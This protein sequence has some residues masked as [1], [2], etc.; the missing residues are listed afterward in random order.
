M[1]V[2]VG[3][4]ALLLYFLILYFCIFRDESNA[5][6]R[7]SFLLAGLAFSI[8]FVV[9]RGDVGTDTANYLAMAQKIDVDSG[10]E[11]VDLDVE[12]GF[13]WLLKGLVF[14]FS[15]PRIA[16]NSISFFIAIYSLHLFSRSDEEFLVFALLLF[17]VFFFDMTMNGLRYGLAFLLAKHAS[18]EYR[19]GNKSKSIIYLAGSVGFQLSGVLV[20]F[21]LWMDK[22]KIS[23]FILSLLFAIVFYLIFQERLDS[24]FAAYAQLQS[25]GVLSGTLPLLLFVAC[26][27]NLYLMSPEIGR[28]FIPLLIFEVLAFVVAKFTYAGLRLQLLVLFVFFCSISSID[29]RAWTKKKMV[30]IP[31]FF[32]IGLLGFMGS[33]KHYVEDISTP[34]SPFLPYHFFWNVQ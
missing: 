20:F 8:V 32:L 24:K 21:L 17:P 6:M 7:R 14:L 22:F 25:P 33:L 9:F 26:L 34:P 11:L 12:V 30:A 1:F 13:Y 28:K 5:P 31:L 15:D 27:L 23:T 16:I 3:S 18:D 19:L 29:Q 10:V 4:Y 2:Y